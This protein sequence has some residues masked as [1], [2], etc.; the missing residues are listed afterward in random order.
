[1]EKRREEK[2]RVEAE[3]AGDQVMDIQYGE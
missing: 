3:L 2:R 1:V